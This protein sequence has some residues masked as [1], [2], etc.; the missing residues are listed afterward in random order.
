MSYPGDVLGHLVAHKLGLRSLPWTHLTVDPVETLS[1]TAYPPGHYT[2][3]GPAV[4][5]V[6][7]VKVGITT[8]TTAGT[9]LYNEWSA[10]VPLAGVDTVLA[11]TDHTGAV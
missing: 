8:A 3:Q 6:V 11:G 4:E 9:N 10:R 2:H 5:K 7:L 1:G